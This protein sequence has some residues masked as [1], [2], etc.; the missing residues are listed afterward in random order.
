MR[1]VAPSLAHRPLYS[2][3]GIQT[4]G[5]ARDAER[6]QGGYMESL[7]TDNWALERES[8]LVRLEYEN[9]ELRRMLGIPPPPSPQPYPPNPTTHAEATEEGD[10]QQ[11][12]SVGLFAG[13][14]NPEPGDERNI[15]PQAEGHTLISLDIPLQTLS[16]TRPLQLAFPPSSAPLFPRESLSH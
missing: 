7:D 11:P 9:Y 16:Q 6:E 4:A 2:L 15:L 12:D 3:A 14:P 10:Q 1:Y 13:P 8:E 5:E